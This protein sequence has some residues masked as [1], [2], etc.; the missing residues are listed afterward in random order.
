[1]AVAAAYTLGV[2]TA[3]HVTPVP[4]SQ[5]K[6]TSALLLGYAAVTHAAE[7]LAGRKTSA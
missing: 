2:L 1:M 4:A 7:K 5:T 3:L 6:W